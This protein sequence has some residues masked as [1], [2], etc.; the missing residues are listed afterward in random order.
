MCVHFQCMKLLLQ[1]CWHE[2]SQTN[3]LHSLSFFSFSV[4]SCLGGTLFRRFI[5]C[6]ILFLTASF[7]WLSSLIKCYIYLIIVLSTTIFN[8]SGGFFFKGGFGYYC[9]YYSEFIKD[10]LLFFALN[11]FNWEPLGWLP[12]LVSFLLIAHSPQESSKLPLLYHI[13]K[14]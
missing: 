8:V 1:R 12:S 11:L 14:L 7:L 5:S 4:L 9:E 3:L 13:L 2:L 6:K 10:Y